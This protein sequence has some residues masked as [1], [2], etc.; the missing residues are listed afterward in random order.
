MSLAI[1][2][3]K[4]TFSCKIEIIKLKKSKNQR[5]HSRMLLL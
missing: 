2:D 1:H 4:D 5:R 3:F